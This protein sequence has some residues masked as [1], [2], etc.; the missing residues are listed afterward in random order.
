MVRL[1]QF[2][3]L[4]TGLSLVALASAI[5]TMRF[6]IHGAEIMIPSFKGLT[7]EEALEK[8]ASLG[9]A[10]T[11]DQRFYSAEVPAGRILTQ[12]PAPGSVVRREWHIRAA[13]SLGPQL[14]P[15]P[16]LV[17]LPQRA[18]TMELRR[19]G[20]E[21]GSIARLPLNGVSPE[22]VIAQDPSGGAAG[23]AEP[24]VNVVVAVAAPPSTISFAMPDFV[25]QP[26]ATAAATISRAG[27]KLASIEPA[28][29]VTSLADPA[30]PPGTVT[31]Q[32]PA[33]GYRVD[34]ETQIELTVAR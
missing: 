24:T 29:T 25:G 7:S 17:G 30:K 31:N 16:N 27:L 13:E 19:L 11:I 21:P 14:R 4:V 15:V 34:A 10:M 2:V 28:M 23:V 20:L 6:A 32:S 26:Y 5:V 18:A 9:V 1:F 12:S 3:I 8:A 33:A 22:T